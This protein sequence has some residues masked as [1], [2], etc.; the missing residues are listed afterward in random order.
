MTAPLA[1]SLVTAGLLLAVW[2]GIT[3]ARRRPADGPQIV[4]SL[5]VE[6]GLAVQS[7]LAVVRIIGG[8]EVAEP[9][10]FVAYSAG[11][12]AP[13]LLGVYLARLERTRWGSLSL[14]FTAVVV[15]VMTLRLLQQWRM[16]VTGV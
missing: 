6:A 11:V 14:C 9:V 8:A 16:G 12:L 5:I 2:T 13:L 3:A 1:Y 7:V 15:A 4:A 10:T